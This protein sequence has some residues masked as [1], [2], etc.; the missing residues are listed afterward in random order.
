[1]ALVLLTC[2]GL[3][4]REFFVPT[5]TKTVDAKSRGM[6]DPVWGIKEPAF[7]SVA[8][9]LSTRYVAYLI[10]GA[11][12][13]LMLP[14]NLEHLGKPLYGV[15]ILVVSVT[16]SFSL[17]DIGYAGAMVRFIARYRASRDS[18]ALNQT[19]S[20]LVVVYSVIGAHDVHRGADT[21]AAPE[22]HLQYR[23][24]EPLGG[25]V[26]SSHRL[27]LYR[28]AVRL[29][30]VRGRGRRFPAASPQQHHER[31]HER[32]CRGGER[33][34]AP[35]RVRT[36]GARGSDD[37]RASLSLLLYRHNAYRAFPGL[38]LRLGDFSRPRLREVTGF[39]VYM[40]LLDIGV[41]LNYAADTLV[42]GRFRR[43]PPRWPCGRPRIGSRS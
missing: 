17:F 4:T 13:L 10:D 36:G 27:R 28:T 37:W 5:Q 19:L 31:P 11:L 3:F 23:S 20:T 22:Q 30:G 38:R 6:A 35:R 40:L 29:L 33:R 1:M 26:R 7:R 12:G 43:D 2:A 15:W 21:A 9:N 25:Q 42:L 24:G 34:R 14:F 39:S 16:V 8:R 32:C 41:K 18:R